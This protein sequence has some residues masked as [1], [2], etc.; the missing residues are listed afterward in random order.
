MWVVDGVLCMFSVSAAWL[1]G[2]LAGWLARE[3]SFTD[4]K[5]EGS[6]E[7]D[8]GDEGRKEG[9]KEEGRYSKDYLMENTTPTRA[10]NITPTEKTRI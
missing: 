7:E 9:R 8:N 3:G 4:T 10:Q 2:W 6:K 1:A 5:A